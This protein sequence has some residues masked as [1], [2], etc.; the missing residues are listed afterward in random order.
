MINR[1]EEKIN[2]RRAEEYNQ[3]A[4]DHWPHLSENDAPMAQAIFFSG[5]RLGCMVLGLINVF[6][7][8]NNCKR[9]F[10]LPKV[11]PNFTKASQLT[12]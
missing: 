11:A 6:L 1:P 9:S 10:S 7:P 12:G 4:D 5:E 2:P 8:R 3:A